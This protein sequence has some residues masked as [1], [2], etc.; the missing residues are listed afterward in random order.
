[1]VSQCSVC[2][3]QTPKLGKH[4]GATTCYPCRAFFRRAQ[5]SVRRYAHCTTTKQYALYTYFIQY[6]RVRCALNIIL[7]IIFFL[8]YFADQEERVTLQKSR[9]LRPE[10]ICEEVLPELPL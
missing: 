8:Y 5:V 2:D 9:R 3:L 4:Y 10:W 6:V 7:D 1:M